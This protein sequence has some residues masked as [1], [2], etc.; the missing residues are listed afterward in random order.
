MRTLAAATDVQDHRAASLLHGQAGAH[1]GG[2]RLRNDVHAACTR[3]LGGFLDGAPLDLGGSKGYAHQHPGRRAQKPVAVHL[4]DEV[5]Q[6]FFRIGE[7][8]DDPVLHGPNRGD[9]AGGAAQHVLG[10]DPD[11]DDDFAAPR[12]FILHCDHRGFVQNNPAFADVNEG[13][14]GSKID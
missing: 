1:G 6:H 11:R 8:G 2:H 4:L 14:C 7:I 12:R 9:V 13:V 10:F 3:P 5:L